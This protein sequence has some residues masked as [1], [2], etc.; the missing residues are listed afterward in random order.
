[1]HLTTVEF[2]LW[3]RH[4]CTHHIHDR[5]FA[6]YY[7][8][9]ICSHSLTRVCVYCTST[10]GSCSPAHRQPNQQNLDNE[11]VFPDHK[12]PRWNF[13][14]IFHSFMVVFRALCGEWV[15][16]LYDCLLVNDDTS[17]VYFCALAFIGSFVVSY[18][19]VRIIWCVCVCSL[20]Y[21][22]RLC[23]LHALFRVRRGGGKHLIES[24]VCPS[25]CSFACI[26]CNIF[27]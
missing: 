19:F 17:I 20:F 21:F 13:I 9:D 18:Y 23:E 1:M 7:I 25:I 16:S 10:P 5:C 22:V 15:E 14:D 4:F 6:F 26:S 2:P 11:Q 8:F 3:F 24:C 12:L 27:H